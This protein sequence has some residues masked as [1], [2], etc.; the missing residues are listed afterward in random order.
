VNYQ[1]DNRKGNGIVVGV[2][3]KWRSDGN[4]L[5]TDFEVLGKTDQ[6]TVRF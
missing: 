3:T 4:E 2:L 6:N 5:E 1:S